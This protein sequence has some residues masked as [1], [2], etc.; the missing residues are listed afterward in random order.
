MKEGW[1]V[2]AEKPADAMDFPRRYS[3]DHGEIEAIALGIEVKADLLL[4][5]ERRGRAVARDQ[6]IAVAG[7]LGELLH[8]K[9]VGR[10]QLVRPQFERLRNEAGFFLDG[11]L[12]RFLLSQVGE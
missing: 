11:E 3:L 8:A 1:L 4:I 6:G 10:L 12:E 7:I 5:D 2:V 9:M